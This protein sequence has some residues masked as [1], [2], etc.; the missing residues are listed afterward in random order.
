MS[1]T[2]AY[3]KATPPVDGVLVTTPRLKCVEPL[4]GDLGLLQKLF[5]DPA[6][7]KFLGGP[8]RSES[9]QKRLQTWEIRW[10]EGTALCGIVEERQKGM[11][12][13]SAGIHPSTVPDQ[14][15]AEISYM[16]LPEY[17]RR[18]YA[19]EIAHAL[20]NY[21]FQ[22]MKLDRLLIT[23]NPDNEPSQ[24]IAQRLGFQ[25][26]GVT[27]YTHPDLNNCTK[28]TVWVLQM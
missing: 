10:K 12:I 19:T 6:M 26:L 4:P 14:P 21:A 8:Y 2:E 5:G 3:F 1:L 25:C 20:I 22:I 15:G 17:Q 11:H 16:I 13:G 28:Q 27:E 7:T 18:G 23:G 24:K 9:I